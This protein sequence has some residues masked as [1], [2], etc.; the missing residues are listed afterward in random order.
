MPV[1]MVERELPGITMD[2]LGAAQKAAIETTEKMSS[3]GKHVSYIRTA[4][5]PGDARAMCM[6]QADSP[7]LVKEANETAGI[8]F[9][10]IVEAMDLSPQ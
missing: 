3:E 6:F 2:Q 4:F 9:T 7:D 10:R 5:V 1:Y 8:P